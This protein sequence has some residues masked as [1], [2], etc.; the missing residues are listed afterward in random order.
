MGNQ[1]NIRNF[2]IIAHIDHGKST[3]ADRLLELTHTIP[4]EKMKAQYLDM[5]DLERERGITIK[6]QPVRMLY[7]LNLKHYILNLID[8]P[9]HVDFSYEVSRSLAAVEGAILLVDATKGIQAQT[10][11]NLE[12]AKK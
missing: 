3:L 4:K 10:I 2:V 1:Y 7:G 6:M 5:M 8:T 9:G 12:L 11:A